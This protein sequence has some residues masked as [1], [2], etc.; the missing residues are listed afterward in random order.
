MNISDNFIRGSIVLISIIIL[1]L[2]GSVAE[3]L[4]DNDESEDNF[5]KKNVFFDSK[6]IF[7]KVLNNK[8]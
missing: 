7:E 2:G 8:L 6:D 3:D 5:V 4:S 1:I